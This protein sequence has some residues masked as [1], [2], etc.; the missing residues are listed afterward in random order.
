MA[1]KSASS[2]NA[3]ANAESIEE[4][5]HR[6]SKKPGVKAWLML[7]R[8]TGAVLKTN[9]QIASV[10]PARATTTNNG[11]NSGNNNNNNNG[12][13]NDNNNPSSTTITA[14]SAAAAAT[15]GTTTAAG[16]SSFST[17]FNANSN[18]EAQAAQELA[19]LVWGFLSSAG[20][21]VDEV[22]DE[23]ELK[24]LRLRTKKQEVV[25]VPEHK[26]LLVVIHDTPPGG[27]RPGSFHPATLA[28]LFDEQYPVL[29]KLGNGSNSTV[30]LAQDIKSGSGR[31]VALKVNRT[32]DS[33]RESRPYGSLNPK[34]TYA[35][36]SLLDRFTHYGQTAS[37]SAPFSNCWVLTPR[38]AATRPPCVMQ[39]DLGQAVSPAHMTGGY[40]R[41]VFDPKR[42]LEYAHIDEDRVPLVKIVDLTFLRPTAPSHGY[43]YVSF[44]RAPGMILRL[45]HLR[46]RGHLAIP[47]SRLPA[48]YRPAGRP[49]FRCERLD[50]NADDDRGEDQHLTQLNKV[51]KPLPP[52]LKARCRRMSCYSRPD[53]EQLGEFRL[54][55]ETPGTSERDAESSLALRYDFSPLEGNSQSAV[56]ISRSRR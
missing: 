55:N 30:W 21:L 22:D 37:I 50:G 4:A 47:L 38:R 36:V 26:Y 7:D 3:N 49:L 54:A 44:L 5:L 24:L 25:I 51:L 41:D 11:T 17:D 18:N 33:N 6:L 31:Y 10:R 53:G 46:K 13:S 39:R 2:A 14:T 23:D 35:V 20:T 45:A 8:S 27:Y 40:P 52:R 42:L 34:R 15:T 12:S 16:S 28:D 43:Q 1:D 56:R 9:G 19:A 48:G 32:G 29:R